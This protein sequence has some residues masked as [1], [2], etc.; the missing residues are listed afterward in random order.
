[1]AEWLA[2]NWWFLTSEVGSPLK[3]DTA[4]YRRR[5]SLAA[6]REGYAYPDLHVFPLG[7]LTRLV[8]QRGTSTWAKTRLL[9]EGEA[10]VDSAEFRETCSDLVDRVVSRLADC[11]IEDTLL[12]QEWA[13][14]RTADEEEADFCRVAAGLGWD[15]YALDDAKCEE[16]LFLAGARL[17][18]PSLR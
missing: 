2:T 13:A 11:G 14:V 7:R 4:G 1:M 15:P 10:L 6:N 3:Q 18:E 5:H 9:D 8:W 17:K 16:V 12:Q